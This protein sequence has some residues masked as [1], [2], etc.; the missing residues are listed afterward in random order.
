[1]LQHIMSAWEDFFFKPTVHFVAPTKPCTEVLVQIPTQFLRKEN[2]EHF[3]LLLLFL[4]VR[5]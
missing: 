2:D 5:L 1:M 4:G 3:R